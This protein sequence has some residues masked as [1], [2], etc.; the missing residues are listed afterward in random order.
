MKLFEHQQLA[1]EELRTGSILVGGVGSGKSITSLYYFFVKVCGGEI[2]DGYISPPTAP[3]KLFIITTA[4]KRDTGE[5]QME[6]VPFIF[7]E[8][9]INVVI[10]SWNNIGKYENETGFFI[11]DEQRVVGSGAWAKSFIKI[12][13]KN[14]WILLSA[15]PGDTWS[16]YIPVFV[17]N[18]FFKNRS[19]FIRKHVI[20]KPFR[21]YPV[22]DRY[23]DEHIL[24]KL[25]DKITVEMEFERK[26]ERIHVDVEVGYRKDL[27]LHALKNSWDP[28]NDEPIRDSARMCQVLRQI[29]N[30]DH[31]R[32]DAISNLVKKKA[33]I[34]Y[35]FDYELE[36]LK[37]CFDVSGWTYAEWNGHKHQPI[38]LTDEW[39]Y[40]VQYAAGAEGWNCTLTDTIIFYSQ[41]HS[42]KLTT[43]AAGRI[44]RL[45][46][47]FKRLYFY[48][49]ISDSGVD[50][51]IKR[52][53]ERKED[54][55]EHRFTDF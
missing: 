8:F 36:I 15:T 30:S 4:R 27:Y 45:N 43:Q 40:L 13:R 33:I 14:D 18:G 37:K 16:D 5:W 51:G 50:K 32:L 19:E 42:Y 41:T 12:A 44:D 38:P 53:L 7:S 23:V 2:G 21:N 26:V 17:A 34:F 20:F 24:E 25:R 39:C 31:S 6:C 3:R 10:D 55:N 1:V 47:P 28:Y 35:N 11:F 52:C 9:G 46:T 54:F 29:V 22:I 48:H 49:L